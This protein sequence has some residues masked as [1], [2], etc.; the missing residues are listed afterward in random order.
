[1]SHADDVFIKNFLAII[2]ALVLFTIFAAIVAGAI[3]SYTWEQMQSGV[4]A[5]L[6]RI[7]PVG[8]VS[9]AA[10][11]EAPSAAAQPQ[12][13]T[14][15]AAAPAPSDEAA[16]MQ[17]A[18]AAPAESSSGGGAGA[19]GM[20]AADA[21]AGESVYSKACVAC[22]A[23]GVAGAPKLGDAAPW[24]DRTGQGFD[25]LV[26]SVLNGKGA[27]PPKGGNMSL[28][29][30]DVRNAVAYMLAESGVSLE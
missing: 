26:Q 12:A 25:G 23:A 13:E 2:G 24:S 4:N 28:S 11:G 6:E 19:G 17:T 3:G 20:A 8:Q 27:M 30:A 10:A 7:E 21:A 29:D 22:H 5:T 16:G 9:V 18:S 15:A 1:M 14:A